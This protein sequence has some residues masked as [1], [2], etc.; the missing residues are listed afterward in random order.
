MNKEKELEPRDDNP[1]EDSALV[2][3]AKEQDDIVGNELEDAFDK[4]PTT[5]DVIGT[6]KLDFHKELP[7]MEF[8]TLVGQTFLLQE[9]RMVEDWDGFFGTS[10]FGLIK[11]Q[12][13]DGR[14]AT[15]LAGGLAVVKQLRGFVNKRRFPIKVNLIE[16]P[17]QAGNYYLFE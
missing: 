3:A 2:Q 11:I 1:D 17:G 9:V 14:K 7:Q 4:A 10:T 5:K 6:G 16:K 8:K 12:M 13:R 15:S